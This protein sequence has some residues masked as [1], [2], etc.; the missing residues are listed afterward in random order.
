[1]FVMWHRVKLFHA[2][3]CV[4]SSSVC[5]FIICLNDSEFGINLSL[6]CI[7]LNF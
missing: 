4:K 2:L 1:M 7:F 5:G 6:I 3:K